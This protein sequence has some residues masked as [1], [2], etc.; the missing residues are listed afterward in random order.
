MTTA[1]FF[2][3]ILGQGAAEG[4]VYYQEEIECEVEVIE[5][6]ECEVEIVE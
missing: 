2:H 6:I 1:S 5:E 3:L 4:N